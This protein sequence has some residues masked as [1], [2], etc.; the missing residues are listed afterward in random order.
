MTR[1]SGRTRV[2]ALGLLLFVAWLVVYPLL[3]VVTESVHGPEGWTAAYLQRFI[4]APQEW[5]VLWNS[6]WISAA[7]VVFSGLIGIPLAFLFEWFDFPGR[8]LLV[9]RR[10]QGTR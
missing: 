10:C 3:L 9:A 1:T 6:L 5:H 4:T 7:T 8:R 2:A